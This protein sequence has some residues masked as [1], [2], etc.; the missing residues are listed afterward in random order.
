MIS[1]SSGPN[2]NE[3][4]ANITNNDP[5]LASLLFNLPTM[6]SSLNINP[7]QLTS[8]LSSLQV[9]DQSQLAN[10]IL[11]VVANQTNVNLNDIQNQYNTIN[12]LANNV[13]NLNISNLMNLLNNFEA[14]DSQNISLINVYIDMV[15]NQ[16][17]LTKDQIK[18]ILVLINKLS[19]LGTNATAEQMIGIFVEFLK[20]NPD[21]TM[22]LFNYI[23]AQANIPS[24]QMQNL[25]MYLPAIAEAAS[26]MNLTQLTNLFLNFAAAQNNLPQETLQAVTST[27]PQLADAISKMDLF[28]LIKILCDLVNQNE[29]INSFMASQLNIDSN[30]LKNTFGFLCQVLNAFQ[31]NMTN[32]DQNQIQGLI[33]QFLTQ[34]PDVVNQFIGTVSSQTGLGPE[35]IQAIMGQI[36]QIASLFTN[37]FIDNTGNPIEFLN[38]LGFFNYTGLT[39]DQLQSIL[40]AASQLFNTNNITPEQLYD[41]LANY[42]I[43]NQTLLSIFIGFLGSQS[44]LSPNQIQNLV[45][46]LPPFLNAVSNSNS[47]QVLTLL[48]YLIYQSMPAPLTLDPNQIQ[49]L[50]V[51]YSQLIN[52]ASQMSPEELINHISDPNVT[53][54]RD[55]AQQLKLLI[56][57]ISPETYNSSNI[58]N[59]TDVKKLIA[60]LVMESEKKINQQLSSLGIPIENQPPTQGPEVTTAQPPNPNVI[61]PN[62]LSVINQ[63]QQD[64]LNQVLPISAPANKQPANINIL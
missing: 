11:G 59:E 56:K 28:Q 5:Q 41:L 40:G 12:D 36:S 43:N 26:S 44:N 58:E 18:S 31:G 54:S 8:I 1:S 33:Q 19:N 34:N 51:P 46:S 62:L 64:N 6:I 9:Q 22:T 60:I 30:Q 7:S 13:Q 39:P 63:L 32:L 50:L 42:K 35:Q 17:G 52:A 3:I 21:L 24:D 61:D 20:V 27:L 45:L 49:S 4:I 47:S 15:T 57:S 55:I 2:I 14:L 38:A 23:G 48:T 53:L 25:F 37:N 10:G 16:T 29:S